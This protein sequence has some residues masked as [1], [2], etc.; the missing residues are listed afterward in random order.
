M[1]IIFFGSDDFALAHLEALAGSKHEILA[2]VTQPDRAKGRGMKVQESPIKLFAK[3]N[4]TTV[5]QPEKILDQ[6]FM[7][8]LK[9]T[10]SDLF[11]VIAYGK[12]LPDSLLDMP[13][14]CSLNVHASLLPKY[15]GAAPI[16]WAIINGE[17]ETG[18]SIIKMSAQ[19]D[20][21]DIVDT[22][23]IPIGNRET[24]V[25]LRE[26]M[27]NKGPDFLLKALENI[28]DKLTKA[29]KQSDEGSSYASKLDRHLGQ[30]EWDKSAILIDQLVRGL[31]PWPGAFTQFKDKKLKILEADFSED[32]SCEPSG[33]VISVDKSGIYVKTGAGILQIKK[34]H[35]QDAKPMDANSFVLG[36]H[37][38]E[39]FSFR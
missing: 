14:I 2:C 28:D 33:S 34:V 3:K 4:K 11:V 19:L 12:I 27:M 16:N 38:A 25:S 6:D 18:L 23:K 15:R 26:K 30:I 20:A 22:L 8:A 17:K 9:E 31:Q 37:I 29:E 36:H 13:R 21:G 7:N 1:K 32:D 5:Y 35:L 10:N 24:A 39:G